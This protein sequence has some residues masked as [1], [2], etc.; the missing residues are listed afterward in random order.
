MC[1][2]PCHSSIGS[3]V[4]P[5]CRLFATV[6]VVSFATVTK[7]ADEPT[8]L[9]PLQVLQLTS[10]RS[11]VG[12]VRTSDRPGLLRWQAA[13]DG[14][15]SNFAWN[16]VDS[17]HWPPSATQPKPIGD[18]RFELAAG[19]MLFGSLR[20]LDEQR[21]EL[22]VA[23]LG[24]IRVRRSHLHRIDRWR[25]G[26]D[27]IYAGPNGLVGWH[28][29]S[30]QKNWRE[31]SG[32]P[33]T[34][35]EHASI[36]GNFGLPERASI[37]F[38]ISWRSKPDFVF[39]VGV[40][41]KKDAFKRAFR[42]EAWGSDIIVQRELKTEADLSIVQELSLGHPGRVHIQAYLDQVNGRIVVFSAGGARLADMTVGSGKSGVLP[43]LYMANLRGDV[44]LEW[45]RIARWDGEIPREVHADQARILRVDGSILDGNLTRL[46]T[47]SRELVLKT[48]KGESRIP[49]G[50]VSSVSLSV[51]KE[52]APRMIRAVYQDG[53]RVSGELVGMEEGVLVL[54][55]PGIQEP[56][57][58]PL[59]GI[60]SLVVLRHE[61]P[62][63]KQGSRKQS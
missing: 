16:Q 18:F 30:G 12:L 34:D 33:M 28:E 49:E 55:V 39:A 8:G 32:R 22:D 26:A 44:R 56:L 29:P 57:Q 7:A 51:T 61:A 35:R 58:L 19:D 42:F 40:D 50:Q 60:R 63:G 36:Q 38:E 14:S 20:A 54:T 37:E 23:R 53:S 25:D 6:V 47:V 10:G 9:P 3:R 15:Q 5:S 31:D 27:V 48:E 41:D 13:S 43:G 2:Q 45:L 46:D 59:A 11:I 62:G 52:D 1:N 17:I 4:P 21:A 24:R